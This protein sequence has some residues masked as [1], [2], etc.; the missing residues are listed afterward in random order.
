MAKKADLLEEAKTLKLDVTEKNT[1]AEIEAAIKTAKETTAEQPQEDEQLAKSG[2]RSKKGLE[3]AEEKAE[4]IARQKGEARESDESEIEEAPEKKKGPTPKTRP[5]LERRSKK[6]Q[7]AAKKI[8]ADKDYDLA[9]AVKLVQE[10]STTKFDGSVE[11]HIRL[12]VDPKK[13]DQNIRGSLVLPHGTGKTARVAVFAEDE[14]AKKA[15]A[16]GADITNMEE[17]TNAIDKGTIEFDVLIAHPS[18][19]AKLGK[20]AKTLGPKGLMPNPKSGTVTA[21]I[22]KAV[23]EAK[24]GRVEYRVDKYGIIHLAVGKVSFKQTDLT[25]N[26][27]TLFKAIREA[28]PASIKGDYVKSISLNATMSPSVSIVKSL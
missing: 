26:I 28:R 22:E 19:M 12:N 1:I 9:D 27:Q 2:K 25:A 11:L 21:D 8:D 20:Y 24:A 6:Y 13:A 10:A 7:E 18:Q 16:A 17:L 15:K 23:K 3:E 5:V 14:D 4:K